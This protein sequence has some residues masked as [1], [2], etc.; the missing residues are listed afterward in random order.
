MK[1]CEQSRDSLDENISNIVTDVG[2]NRSAEVTATT[3]TNS[4]T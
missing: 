1:V 4:S 3:E 2:F